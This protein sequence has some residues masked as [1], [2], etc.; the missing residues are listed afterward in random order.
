MRFP[1]LLLA[2]SKQLGLESLPR[3]FDSNG[4]AE[5]PS[6]DVCHVGETQKYQERKRKQ[7]AFC[8]SVNPIR[9]IRV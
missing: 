2:E 5:A 8:L 6:I 7:S 1:L 9:S 4:D 3:P